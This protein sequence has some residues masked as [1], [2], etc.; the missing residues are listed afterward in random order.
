MNILDRNS[1]EGAKF[2]G[3]DGIVAADIVKELRKHPSLWQQP[4]IV[5]ETC[6]LFKTKNIIQSSYAMLSS[7]TTMTASG[8]EDSVPMLLDGIKVFGSPEY[9]SILF[10]S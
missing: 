3:M 7:A 10:I 9:I 6:L 4:L 5:T 2:D 1:R 8:I